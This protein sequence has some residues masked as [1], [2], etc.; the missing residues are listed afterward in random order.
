MIGFKKE[1]YHF[2][3]NIVSRTV[4]FLQVESDFLFQDSL[5]LL[6]HDRR[7]SEVW[8]LYFETIQNF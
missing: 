6:H 2:L 8:F 1:A 3:F 7:L 5:V 4:Q